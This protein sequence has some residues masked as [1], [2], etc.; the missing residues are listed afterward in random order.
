[1]ELFFDT[2]GLAKQYVG[3]VGSA[4]VNNICAPTSGNSIFIAEI[5][6]VEITS[7]IVRRRRGGSLTTADAQAALHNSIST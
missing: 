6:V 3:E 4:W 2:S 1:M 5:T 7:A